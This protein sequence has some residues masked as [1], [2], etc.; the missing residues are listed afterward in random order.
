MRIPPSSFAILPANHGHSNGAAKPEKALAQETQK[1]AP[2]GLERVLARLQ[3]L[4]EPS[5]GQTNATDRISRNLAR[6]AENQAANTLPVE[7][8]TPA[9]EAEAEA[10]VPV[11]APEAAIETLT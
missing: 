4:P 3:S 7:S 9:P 11:G 10:V 5:A 1:V 8:A 2:P 6:Y